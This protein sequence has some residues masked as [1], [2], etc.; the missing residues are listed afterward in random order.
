MR[1]VKLPGGLWPGS[2]SCGPRPG[3]RS[4]WRA[5]RYWLRGGGP[6]LRSGVTSASCWPSPRSVSPGAGSRAAARTQP[7]KRRRSLSSG[8]GVASCTGFTSQGRCPP[9][10]ASRST[11]DAGCWWRCWRGSSWLLC[12]CRPSGAA[13]PPASSTARCRC[14]R[15]AWAGW[16]GAAAPA[17]SAWPCTP[18]PPASQPSP[19]ATSATSAC[20]SARWPRRK[21]P[22][23]SERTWP[24]GAWFSSCSG[25]QCRSR[26]SSGSAGLWR[27]WSA[28]G[29]GRSWTRRGAGGLGRCDRRG[30]G[31]WRRRRSRR[32][33]V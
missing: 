17:P 23:W 22:R 2:T 30:C 13:S 26:V 4:C 24:P 32:L 25:V 18:P 28:C 29:T 20:T 19:C 8:S 6:R 12:N 10:S 5:R 33:C 27:M 9:R 11:P 7:A 14:C 16:C 21:L 1:D 31:T 15:P 3:S